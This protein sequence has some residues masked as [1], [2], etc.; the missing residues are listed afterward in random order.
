M[1]LAATASSDHVR[2][3]ALQLVS[4][5]LRRAEK[6]ERVHP[7]TPQ[8]L[9]EKTDGERVYRVTGKPDAEAST[10]AQPRAA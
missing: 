1:K 8:G 6:A 2:L 10:S 9:S 3:M 4:V 7:D 5:W